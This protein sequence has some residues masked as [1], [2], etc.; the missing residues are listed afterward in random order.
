M[1]GFIPASS[2]KTKAA[3]NPSIILP[4]TYIIFINKSII[5]SESTTELHPSSFQFPAPNVCGGF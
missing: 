3:F 4:S 1:A 2:I 5:S